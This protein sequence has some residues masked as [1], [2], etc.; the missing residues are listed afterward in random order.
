MPSIIPDRDRFRKWYL[1][2]DFAC[3]LT[4]GT[5]LVIRKGYRFNGHS[6]KPLHWIFPQYDVDIVAALV[7]DYLLDTAPWHRFNR[8]YIDRQY[9]YFMNQY[10]YG[11]RKF[12][13]PKAVR[14]WGFLKCTMWGDYRGTPKEGTVIDVVVNMV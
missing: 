3:T 9:V 7:H 12:V 1:D 8:D 13:M 11:L 10:S 14:V 4:D 6:T 5:V 2:Q